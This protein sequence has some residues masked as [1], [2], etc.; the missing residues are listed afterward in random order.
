MVSMVT[1]IVAMVTNCCLGDLDVSMVE[2][3][4]A[5]NDCYN[6]FSY[7]IQFCQADHFV[8]CAFKYNFSR[9]YKKVGQPFLES[10]SCLSL[11]FLHYTKF[12]LALCWVGVCHVVSVSSS[13]TSSL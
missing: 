11:P 7:Y 3:K 2:H 4:G 1:F 13:H 5:W 9:N 8:G 10:T 6:L 12:D